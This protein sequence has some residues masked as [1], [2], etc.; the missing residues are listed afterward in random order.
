M[1]G[2][3]GKGQPQP[4]GL[5][6]PNGLGIYDLH[7]NRSEWCFDFYKLDYYEESPA[8]DPQGPLYGDAHVR[9]GAGV[10]SMDFNVSN[11]HRSRPSNSQTACAIRVGRTILSPTEKEKAETR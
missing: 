10:S 6:E 9:R 5:L 7:G 11:W 1:D 8:T 4:V 3:T 2:R